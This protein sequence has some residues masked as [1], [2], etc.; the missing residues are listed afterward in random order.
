P[1]ALGGVIDASIIRKL[2][3]SIICGGANNILD[4]YDEDGVALQASGIAYVPDFIAN[5]GGIIELVGAWLDMPQADRGQKIADIEQTA[6]RVLRDA[7]Q[8]H[9][10]YAAA[11]ALA[12]KR[13]AEGI[14]TRVTAE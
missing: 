4:D 5:A 8:Y 10:A 9:S 12:G 6:G 11:V 3:C 1:C 14:E 7:E 2:R 13:I